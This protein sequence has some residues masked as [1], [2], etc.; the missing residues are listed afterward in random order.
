MKKFINKHKFS[1]LIF[2]ITLGLMLL[3]Q[4]VWISPVRLGGNDSYTH[5]AK[6]EILKTSG[7]EEASYPAILPF[8]YWASINADNTLVFD[9]FLIVLTSISSSIAFLKVF[10]AIYFALAVSLFNKVLVHGQKHRSTIFLIALVGSVFNIA[11]FLK[12]TE[13]RSLVFSIVMF[14]LTLALLFIYKKKY[15]LLIPIAFI[16]TLIHTTVFL[17]FVPIFAL[18][19]FDIKNWKKYL[20][21]FLY[22]ITGIFFAVLIYPSQNFYII[23]AIQPII[24]FIYKTIPFKIDGA[25]EVA[26]DLTNPGYLLASNV[27][28]I[29]VLVIGLIT[30]TLHYSKKIKLDLDKYKT[31]SF[32]LFILFFLLDLFSRRFSDYLT[33]AMLIFLVLNIDS[34]FILFTKIKPFIV[35]NKYLLIVVG[36]ICMIGFSFVFYNK[37]L[38]DNFTNTDYKGD[39]KSDLPESYGASVYIN[40]YIEKGSVIYNNAWEDFPYF[41]YYSPDY[42]YAAGMELGFMYLYDPAMLKFYQDFRAMRDFTETGDDLIY[43]DNSSFQDFIFTKFD[44]SVIVIK[45]GTSEEMSDYLLDNYYTVGV[46]KAYEDEFYTIYRTNSK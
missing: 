32:L 13:L 21:M 41:I 30:Y 14:F 20:S 40:N 31:T 33:P 43:T 27:V 23:L 36:L 7:I 46:E 37:Y 45:K 4:F 28:N 15:W 25:F 18:L 17:M 10:I 26:G 29:L 6:A 35:K 2:C 9:Y 8:T 11:F 5:L 39:I 16:Y 12:F 38:K 44:S 19:V 42:K 1:I 24:P 34:V 3:Y 22:C